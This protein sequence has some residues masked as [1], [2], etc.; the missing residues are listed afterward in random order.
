MPAAVMSAASR[1]PATTCTPWPIPHAT[2]QR[3]RP[4][5]RAE[6]AARPAQ[7]IQAAPASWFHMST[8]D[9]S[10]PEATHARAAVAAPGRVIPR[11]RASAKRPV[12]ASRRWATT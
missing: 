10:G 11:R 1:E 9:R 4:V 5:R 7:G 6:I 8:T 12:P 2:A 3:R